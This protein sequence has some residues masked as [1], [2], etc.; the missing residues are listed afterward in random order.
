LAGREQGDEGC[1]DLARVVVA[2]EQ[3]VFATHGLATELALGS[4]M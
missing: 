1:V 2:H 3:P 4:V